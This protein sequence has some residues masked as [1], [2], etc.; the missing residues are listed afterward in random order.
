MCSEMM[1]ADAIIVQNVDDNDVKNFNFVA[2][3]TPYIHR[4]LQLVSG[5]AGGIYVWVALIGIENI[6]YM[7]VNKVKQASPINWRG[8]IVSLSTLLLVFIYYYCALLFSSIL[9]LVF[10]SISIFSYLRKNLVTKYISL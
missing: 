2:G 1:F 7:Y 9:V 4:C 5:G 8:N 6:E 10:S 3:T